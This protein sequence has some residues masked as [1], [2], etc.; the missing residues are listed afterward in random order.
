M[1][2]TMRFVSILFAAAFAVQAGTAQA[3]IKKEWV[4]YRHGDVKLKGIWS[5]TTRSPASGRPC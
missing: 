3:E 2:T 4:E 5:T 1:T